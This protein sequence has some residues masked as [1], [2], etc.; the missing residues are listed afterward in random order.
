[1]WYSKVIQGLVAMGAAA[2]PAVIAASKDEDLWKNVKVEPSKIPQP[3]IDAVVASM[4]GGKVNNREDC[5]KGLT[6]INP[7]DAPLHSTIRGSEAT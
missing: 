2:V 1:M 3:E 7:E 6:L 5:L 4:F